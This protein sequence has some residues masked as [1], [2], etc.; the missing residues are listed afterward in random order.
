M[1]DQ[2]LNDLKNALCNRPILGHPD[3]TN[4]A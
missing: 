1:H 3:F 2:E 4:E